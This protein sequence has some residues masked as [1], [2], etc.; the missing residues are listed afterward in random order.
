[1]LAELA[2][3]LGID[4]ATF[5]SAF[6]S[7]A[8]RARTQAHFAQSRKAGVRGFPTLILQRGEQ[9]DRIVDGWQPLDSVRAELDRLLAA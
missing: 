9:L 5:L 1:V 3:G 7:D 4:S 6:D 8:A 2:T